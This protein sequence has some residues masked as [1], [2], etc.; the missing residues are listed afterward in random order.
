MK[1]RMK[2]SI[3]KQI[4]VFLEDAAGR[5]EEMTGVLGA[6][7]INI[8]AISVAENA[9]YGIVRMVISHTEAAEASLKK[10]DFMVNITDVLCVE[11]PDEPGSLA[12]VFAELSKEN[13]N[14]SYMYGY[15]RENVAPMIIK[16]D[17]P[18]RALELFS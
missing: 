4:S 5:L 3:V 13:I 11:I 14:V 18:V 2:V 9:G 15:S 16:V 8:S 7:G 10:A 1:E 17:D 6:A 12:K